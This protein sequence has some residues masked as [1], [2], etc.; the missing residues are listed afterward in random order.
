MVA[1]LIL[2]GR[3]DQDWATALANELEEHA[4]VRFQLGISLPKVTFGPSVVR[5]LLWSEAALVEGLNET[6]AALLRAE[7]GHSV[8]VLRGAG[9]PPS[10]LTPPGLA[11]SIAVDN[12]RQAAEALRAAIPKVVARVTSALTDKRERAQTAK[13]ARYRELDRIVTAITIV[14]AAGAVWAFNLGGV[15]ELAARFFN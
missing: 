8:L 9:E 6:A 14:L 4:P 11:E 13:S 10:A 3:A 5:V 2:H 1:L 7:P 12:P 15:R